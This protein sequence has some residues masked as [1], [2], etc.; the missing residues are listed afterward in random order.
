MKSSQNRPSVYGGGNYRHGG[1]SIPVVSGWGGYSIEQRYRDIEM[2]MC[3]C[4]GRLYIIK[5]HIIISKDLAMYLGA[6]LPKRPEKKN[7]DGMNVW[8][9]GLQGSH[10]AGSWARSGFWIFGTSA[11]ASVV[12]GFGAESFSRD[13]W[14]VLGSWVSQ[15]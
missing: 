2:H 6:P 7:G 11:A 14:T 1:R 9:G 12:L 5:Y 8:F 10:R 13:V 4:V 15:G 3:V